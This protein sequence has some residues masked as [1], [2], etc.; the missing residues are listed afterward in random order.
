MYLIYIIDNIHHLLNGNNR[1]N[2]K[3]IREQYPNVL[4]N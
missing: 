1:S 3:Q 2:E 4:A